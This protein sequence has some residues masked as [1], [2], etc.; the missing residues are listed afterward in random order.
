[1]DATNRKTDGTP[2]L[3]TAAISA[4]HQGNKI[5]AIKIVREERKIGLKEAKDAVEDYVRTQPALQVSLA[6]AQTAAKRNAL[7]W[8]VILVGLVLVAYYFVAQP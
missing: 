6:A 4:L 2:Q 8:L 1:M 3:S 5:G 7:R